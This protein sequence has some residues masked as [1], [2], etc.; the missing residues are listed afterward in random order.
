MSSTLLATTHIIAVNLFLLIYLVKTILLFANKPALERFIKATKVIEMIISTLFLVTGIWLFIILGAIKTFQIV[1]LVGVLLAVPLAVVGFRKQNKALALLSF[2]LIVG[3]YGLAEMAKNKPFIPMNVVV[4]GNSGDAAETGI[5]T[6]A[7][8][9]SMCH[10]LDGKKKYRDAPDLSAS[11]LN[12]A[13]VSQLISEGSKGKMP[14]FRETLNDA[15]VN[16]VAAYIL[17]LRG[18]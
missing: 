11:T 3:V 12:P 9:C 5:R 13:L 16:A 15:E 1:K 18:K 14:S 17:T 10:G 7:A 4:N 6:F 8:N 2:L